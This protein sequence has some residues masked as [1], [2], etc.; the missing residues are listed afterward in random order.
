MEEQYKPKLK[1]L[2]KKY[3][4]KTSV[5]SARLPKEMI[6]DIDKVA[7]TTGRTR[8]EIMTICLEYALKNMEVISD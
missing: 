1:I 7:V 6:K 3:T 5:I 2:Q 4:G 8:N